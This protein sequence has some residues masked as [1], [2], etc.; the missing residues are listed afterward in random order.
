MAGQGD[1][2]FN[3]SWRYKRKGGAQNRLNFLRTQA[4]QPPWTA[5]P[6]WLDWFF[7]VAGTGTGY[8]GILKRW[9][10]ATWVKEPLQTFLAGS[11]Q[12]K[13]L[14]RW[15]GSSWKLIDTTGI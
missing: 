5:S 12:S 6:A 13:P 1:Y 10:G 4:S 9:T 11:W 2:P 8:S 3:S 15:D 14:K 7:G